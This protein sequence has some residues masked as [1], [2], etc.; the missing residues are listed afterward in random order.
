MEV[1]T[2]VAC[3]LAGWILWKMYT[4]PPAKTIAQWHR[5]ISLQAPSDQGPGGPCGLQSQSLLHRSVA[6]YGTMG[7]RLG[8]VSRL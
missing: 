8:L 6:V 7:I 4:G 5:S 1:S 3:R 2:G